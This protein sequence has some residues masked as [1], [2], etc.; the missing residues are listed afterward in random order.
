MIF[1]ISWQQQ[2]INKELY[3]DLPKVSDKVAGR[4]LKLA[5]HCLRHPEPAVVLWEP[6]HG[7][8]VRMTSQNHDRQPMS[9]LTW[10]TLVSR[11]KMR[12]KSA[13][14]LDENWLTRSDQFSVILALE[15]AFLV[16]LANVKQ[17]QCHHKKV[18]IISDR[19]SWLDRGWFN[20]RCLCFQYGNCRF[21]VLSFKLNVLRSLC[22][23]TRASI[24]AGALYKRIR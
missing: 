7:R 22:Q 18:Q 10:Q 9:T 17:W 24:R 20:G 13:V 8:R 23:E 5:G 12:R 15:I 19:A 6:S 1:N 3:G 4:R 21:I 14:M 2:I 16:F 11:I